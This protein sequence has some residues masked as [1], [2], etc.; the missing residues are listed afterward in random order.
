MSGTAAIGPLELP[1]HAVP[2]ESP[3]A[4]M[5]YDFLNQ[6]C[7]ADNREGTLEALIRCQGMAVILLG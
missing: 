3:P 1:L 6:H 7:F 4:F 2:S 5:Q